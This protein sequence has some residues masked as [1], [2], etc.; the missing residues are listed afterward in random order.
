MVDVVVI[1]YNITV[2]TD[3]INKETHRVTLSD[4]DRHIGSHCHNKTHTNIIAQTLSLS[5]SLSLS[6]PIRVILLQN[7]DLEQQSQ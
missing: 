5:L 2:I 1:I 4:T 3:V 6:L 7:I